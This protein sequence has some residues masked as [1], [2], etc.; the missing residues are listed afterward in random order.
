MAPSFFV[1][2]ALPCRKRL[3][4]LFARQFAISFAQFRGAQ[5]LA[6]PRNRGV[7]VAHE[8]AD[9]REPVPCGVGPSAVARHAC[10]VVQATIELISFAAPAR[11]D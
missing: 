7:W 4:V 8:M 9:R 6:E 10:S 11:P 2:L 3:V 1:A 5:V